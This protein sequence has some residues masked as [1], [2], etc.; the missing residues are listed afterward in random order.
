MTVILTSTSVDIEIYGSKCGPL[1]D[2]AEL[3]MGK[4]REVTSFCFRAKSLG[5][6]FRAFGIYWSV[7]QMLTSGD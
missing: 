1:D 2:Q 6:Q 7:N 5:D 4:Y 3:P